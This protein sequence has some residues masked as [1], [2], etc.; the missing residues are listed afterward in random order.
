M[1]KVNVVFIKLIGAKG[2]LY[3]SSHFI[4]IVG[5]IKIKKENLRIAEIGVDKAATTKVILKI[6]GKGDRYD[7]FDVV[8]CPFFK[9]G[10]IKTDAK[11]IIH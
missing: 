9:S 8:T 4:E 7:L 10:K 6:I 5:L 11:I 3:P 2:D 1:N